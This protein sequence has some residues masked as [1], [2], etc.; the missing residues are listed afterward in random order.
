MTGSN[1]ALRTLMLRLLFRRLTAEPEPAP[2][3]VSS[4]LDVPVRQATAE[5]RQAGA[6]CRVCFEAVSG[7][8]ITPC[9]CTGTQ[10]WIHE[11]CLRQ[12]QRSLLGQR[13]HRAS[14]CSVCTQLFALPPPPLPAAP[15]Q[16]GT[17]LVAAP[18]L[19]GSFKQAVV[20]ICH[21]DEH[22]V[23]GL[24]LT[25]PVTHRPCTPPHPSGPEAQ[26]RRALAS[27]HPGVAAEWRRGGPVCGGRLGVTTY[28]ALHNMT[29]APG[30]FLVVGH[31]T[32]APAASTAAPALAPAPAAVPTSTT[33][34]AVVLA[35][36][37]APVP[38]PAP[39]PAATTSSAASADAADAATARAAE[40]AE[41]EGATADSV[42]A[43]AAGGNTAA[44]GGGAVAAGGGTAEAA[45]VGAA[46]ADGIF[47]AVGRRGGS[48]TELV[49]WD[50]DE[51]VARVGALAVS[52]E[53]STE[54]AEP[55]PRLLLFTG[56]CR[57]GVQQ[58]SREFG[59]GRWGACAARI[60]DLLEVPVEQMWQRLRASGRLMHAPA[61]DQ[62]Q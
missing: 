23:H 61:S 24:L 46:A 47:H 30:S 32:A 14:R 58:L 21:A 57:W 37:A 11:H 25:S 62:W 45:A 16:V 26:A 15:V 2:A 43:A 59:E 35:S 34:P 13:D 5:E 41:A 48:N 7:V 29:T 6:I 36:T 28:S 19:G 22:G 4:E 50:G 38:V 9:A 52:T 54:R 42:T 8:L 1:D 53:R 40:A 3:P 56:H 27:L 51:L 10:Q 55:P 44:A 18:V 49:G 12:W 17:L 31:P 60:D 33:A 20:L 39:A